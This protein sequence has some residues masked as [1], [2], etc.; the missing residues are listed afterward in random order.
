MYPLDK[1]KPAPVKLDD[2]D[3]IVD[4]NGKAF[5]KGPDATWLAVD[6]SNAHTSSTVPTWLQ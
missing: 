5:F 2:Y 4:A 6:K 1:V 3:D